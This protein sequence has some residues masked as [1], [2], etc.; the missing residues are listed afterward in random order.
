MKIKPDFITN[1]STAS[2]YILKKYL[3]EQQL[4]NIRNHIKVCQQMIQCKNNQLNI[5]SEDAWNIT[6][7]EDII[8]GFTIIDNFDMYWFLVEIG[9]PK[10]KINYES[11]NYDNYER[12]SDIDEVSNSN[13][14]RCDI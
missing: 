14:E 5:G 8:K 2:F 1:S 3:T 4:D 11:D 7:N 12:C 10:D 13:D 6:E 9:V